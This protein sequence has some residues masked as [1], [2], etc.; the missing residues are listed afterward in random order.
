[1][2]IYSG[3]FSSQKDYPISS[4]YSQ[5]V[6]STGLSRAFSE[7]VRFNFDKA[8]T[9]NPYA[10]SIFLFFFYQLFL[11]IISS[12]LLIKSKISKNNLLFTDIFISIL[13]FLYSFGRFIADQ[14]F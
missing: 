3:I 13:L 5:N 10:I 11:R 12:L 1:M 7:I 2:L 9:Y 8:K 4:M 6:S 14:I